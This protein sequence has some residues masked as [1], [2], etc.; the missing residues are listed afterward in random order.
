MKLRKIF[1]TWKELIACFKDKINQFN[2]RLHTLLTWFHIS[3]TVRTLERLE[4]NI[5]MWYIHF[6]IVLMECHPYAY[7]LL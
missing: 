7:Q 2:V 1:G 4:I 3:K 5:S 6:I